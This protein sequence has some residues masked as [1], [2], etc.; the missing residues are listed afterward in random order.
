MDVLVLRLIHIGAGTFWVGA[1]FTFFVFVQPTAAVLGPDAQKFVFHL[2]HNRRLPFVIL[3]AGA[4]TVLAGIW[5]L[6]ITSNGLDPDRLLDASRLGYTVGGVAAIVTLGIGALYVFPRTRTVER[7]I[8]RLLAEGRPPTPDE[9]HTLARTA[10][11]SR[12][13][14]W[15]VIIGL[16]IAVV[17]MATARLWG[18]LLPR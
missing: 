16:V 6:V 8:G 13:A 14:G 17:A 10:R 11:E 1:V 18:L 5:L 4:V 3:S 9:G 7:I 2:I 12:A 15:L